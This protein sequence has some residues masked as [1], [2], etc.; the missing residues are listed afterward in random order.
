[1]PRT[2]IDL[3]RDNYNRLRSFSQRRHVPLKQAVNTLLSR[4]LSAENATEK[5]SKSPVLRSFNAGV[6]VDPADRDALY[7]AMERSK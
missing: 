7:G 2:T 1:M 6:T 3:S 4:A 5:R